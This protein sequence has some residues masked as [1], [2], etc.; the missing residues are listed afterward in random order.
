[1]MTST[2]AADIIKR[3]SFSSVSPASARS[4]T[5]S[6]ANISSTSAI[7]LSSAV[8]N[9]S[10]SNAQV[11]AS[12]IQQTTSVQVA[13]VPVAPV[14]AP[15]ESSKVQVCL[16]VKPSDSKVETIKVLDDT[17]VRATP[18]PGAPPTFKTTEFSFSK[19]FG[20]E[21]TQQE[22][23][24]LVAAPLI[25]GLLESGKDGLIFAYGVT[26]SGKTFTVEGNQK[27][28]G[29]IPQTLERIFKLAPQSI[30]YVS[31]LQM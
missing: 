11:F 8:A 27:N 28:P 16:R 3:L 31:Y 20:P 1:M 12:A 17:K 15:A 29:I 13:T 26:N 30:V 7:L 2:T 19:V 22:V 21:A 10:S 23:F 25:S 14:A 5:M 6:F 4:S 9:A 18:P 24:E